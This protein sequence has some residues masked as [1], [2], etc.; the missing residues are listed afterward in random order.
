LSSVGNLSWKH[1]QTRK[2]FE[3]GID[4]CQ[5]SLAFKIYTCLVIKA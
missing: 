5:I 1:L 2:Y 3:G 4:W